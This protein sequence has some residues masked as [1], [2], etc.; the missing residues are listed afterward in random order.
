MTDLTLL[1]KIIAHPLIFIS[2]TNF[3]SSNRGSDVDAAILGVV[4]LEFHAD[5]DGFFSYN[6]L[7]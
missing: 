5:T 2:Y 1:H 3:K 6:K 4:Y 7:C